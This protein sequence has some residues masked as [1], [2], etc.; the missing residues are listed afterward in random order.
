[1]AH[2][3]KL[4]LDVKEPLGFARN[5]WP[6]SAGVPFP[7]GTVKDAS[8]MRIVDGGTAS[9]VQARALS[10]WPDGSVRWAL[11]DWQ[12][13]LKP[14]GERHLSVELGGPVTVARP[15]KASDQGDHIEVD[16]G[17][18][19]F[20]VPKQRYAVMEKVRLDDKPMTAGPL[21]AF[22]NIDAQRIDG[23][24]PTAVAITES[25]PFRVRIEIRGHYAAA[26][27]YVVRIDAF[28]GQPFVR[29]LHSFEQH[30]ADAYTF[31][32][33]IGI[34]VPLKLEGKP[35]YLAG[36]EKNAPLT[37][38]VPAKGWTLYQQDN[39]VL[40]VDGARRAGHAAGWVDVHDATHGVAM[41]ARF[42]WQE[43]PQSFAV[44]T[45]GLTYNMWAPESAPAKVGMGAA[46]TH[47]VVLYFHGRFAP[48]PHLLAALT[49]TV[50][51]QI[52]PRWI[53]ASGA[54][55]NSVA[56][57]AATAD[58]FRALAAAHRR[59][60]ASADVEPWDD[61]G[62]VRC[63][64]ARKKSARPERPRRGFYGMFNWGDWNFPGY[65]DTTKGC[66][67]WGNLE[68]DMTQVLALAYAA[69]G[70]RAFHEGMVA[71][72]RHF[73]DV[74]RIYEQHKRP[75]W[76]GMNHP[77]NPLHFSFELGGVDLGH[78]WTEGLLSYYYLTGDERGLEAARGIADYLIRRLRSGVLIGNPRQWGWPQIALVAA[79]E[80]TGEEKYKAAAQEYARTGLAAHPPDKVG[81]FKM[82]VLAEALAYTHS[83]TQDATIKD[84][85][86][87]YAAAVTARGAKVDARLYPAVA[88]VGRI[89][90]E[91]RYVKAAAA[92][93]P[94]LKFGNW[95][96]PFTIAGRLGF[97]ILSSTAAR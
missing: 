90:G 50:L 68:Y 52:D 15:V 22:F 4:T 34:D 79:Y 1:M 12:A 80:A 58:F 56:P 7:R 32:R 38:A 61:S 57:D 96:K 46:K 77:K 55:R 36:L 30:S 81:D 5:H 64:D 21:V 85:L 10:R 71:A 49:R 44:R 86:E 18:L 47:E 84:W 3:Q 63:P 95:G 53:A 11:L 16:T 60:Q 67:A 45:T 8:L 75:I 69:T 51:P 66:D 65:H 2:P 13:D 24:V 27:D 41:A 92:T 43:Y 35:T 25:G 91:Q 94:R 23:Q 40:H 62:E 87:H 78:T 73:M 70:E 33:Q 9:A 17:P 26:F 93:V 29:V 19:Q 72:A 28:A 88:Y 48:E 89:S 14:H 37:G 74:D 39:D 59:Y 20:S 97:S 82:G 42:F 83:V 54:L 31:V 6:L 76:V